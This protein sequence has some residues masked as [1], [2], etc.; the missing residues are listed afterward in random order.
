MK[1]AGHDIKHFRGP[2]R[3]FDNEEAAFAAVDKKQDQS[4][5]RRRDS[6][7]RPQG[8]TRHAR[9]ARRHRRA[10]RRRSRRFRCSAH[11]RPLLRRHARLHGRPRCAR[12]RQRRPHRRGRRRRHHRLRHSE[13][14]TRTSNSATTKSRSA[15]PTGKLPPRASPAASWPSTLCSFHSASHRRGHCRACFLCINDSASIGCSRPAHR[16]REGR[17]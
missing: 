13:S 15:S 1:V 10:G 4:R 16:N 9:N 11:R 17:L 6:L 8:R 5:R 3:V 7:R 12:S 2:A 14:H